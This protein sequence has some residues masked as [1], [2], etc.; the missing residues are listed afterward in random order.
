MTRRKKQPAIPPIEERRKP[1]LSVTLTGPRDLRRCQACGGRHE[2]ANPLIRFQEHDENDERTW[3]IVVLHRK[4]ADP[5]IEPHPRIYR[6]L[7]AGEHFPGCMSICF[8]CRHIKRLACSSPASKRGGGA[9][10][11]FEWETP[12]N[13]IHLN[14]GGGR[15]TWIF[16]FHGPVKTCSGREDATS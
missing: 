4:C 3:T 9:G 7:A 11:K 12:P 14:F 15:G 1:G 5:I 13:S 6:E 10:L 16:Q 2:E 8:G